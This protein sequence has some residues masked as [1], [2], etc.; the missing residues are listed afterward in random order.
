MHSCF[1]SDWPYTYEIDLYS[2]IA[3]RTIFLGNSETCKFL[4]YKSTYFL[5][6]YQIPYLIMSM[7]LYFGRLVN[8]KLVNRCVLTNVSLKNLENV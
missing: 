5:K 8:R 1:L 3:L 4:W 7:V 6:H 2:V